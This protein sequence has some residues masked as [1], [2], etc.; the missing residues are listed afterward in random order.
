MS[1]EVQNSIE[2]LVNSS[3][4]IA[5][6]EMMEDADTAVDSEL[7]AIEDDG[8]A[9]PE[10]LDLDMV[11]GDEDI[12]AQ[13]EPD[14]ELE[15]K[16]D[17]VLDE[18]TEL[19]EV[20][21]AESLDK[22]GSEAIDDEAVDTEIDVMPTE[23]VAETDQGD[24]VPVESIEAL[25]NEVSE[26]ETEIQTQMDSLVVKADHLK[27]SIQSEIQRVS[28]K[29]EELQI[30]VTQLEKQLLESEGKVEALVEVQDRQQETIKKLI[31]I[32]KGVNTKITH[33]YDSKD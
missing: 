1:K 25:E 15:D 2:E 3:L 33:L 14:S 26:L 17:S 11:K 29:N 24:S 12:E 18:A 13:I 9:E 23:E 28:D 5:A 16:I 8:L 19:E 20:V 7:E 31:R 32:L 4:D 21:E 22:L 27:N 10:E 30:Q 6:E